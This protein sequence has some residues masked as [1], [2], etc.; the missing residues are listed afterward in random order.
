MLFVQSEKLADCDRLFD[1]IS[2]TFVAF[3]YT[4]SPDIKPQA[5]NVRQFTL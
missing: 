2:E 4:I 3:C 1:R 5:L